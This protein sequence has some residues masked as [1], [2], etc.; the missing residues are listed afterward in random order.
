MTQDLLSSFLRALPDVVFFIPFFEAIDSEEKRREEKGRKIYLITTGPHAQLHSSVL[1]VHGG[2]TRKKGTAQKQ[3]VNSTLVW[4]Y[5]TKKVTS[6]FSFSPPSS[7][8][9]VQISTVQSLQQ[10]VG[11]DPT[12][13]IH[14][15]F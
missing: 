2:G 3:K 9:A 10:R 7:W 11:V 1:A 8:I 12:R 4:I 5:L 6:S 15:S 13:S 14:P